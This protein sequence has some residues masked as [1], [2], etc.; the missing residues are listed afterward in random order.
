LTRK[1]S[2]K[3]CCKGPLSGCKRRV[4]GLSMDG[5]DRPKTGFVFKGVCAC[6]IYCSIFAVVLAF[7]S[8]RPWTTSDDMSGNRLSDS[9]SSKT[10]IGWLGPCRNL[11]F[12]WINYRNALRC[13]TY[14]REYFDEV[15]FLSGDRAAKKLTGKTVIFL[16]LRGVSTR[17]RASGHLLRRIFCNLCCSLLSFLE[18]NSVIL[19]ED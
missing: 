7:F 17:V 14:L 13:Y 6:M 18:R 15:L 19:C 10:R 12:V 4:T 1:V 3:R 8:M 9:L 5:D 11:V 16:Q 2:G